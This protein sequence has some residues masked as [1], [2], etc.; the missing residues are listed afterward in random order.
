M[1]DHRRWL[2]CNESYPDRNALMAQLVPAG[3]TVLDVGAGQMTLRQ[4]LPPG[5]AYTPLDLYPRSPDTLVC[6]LNKREWPA[7]KWDV[8]VCSGV[9]EY[10]ADPEWL[11]D[12]LA[13]SAGLVI[14]SYHGAATSER[15]RGYGFLTEMSPGQLPE[16]A[17]R[18]G[19]EIV[20]VQPF[21]EQAIYAMVRKERHIKEAPP[22]DPA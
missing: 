7:G 10:V 12:R 14:A 20:E 21:G 3:R 13:E 18:S 17:R 22:Y 8:A 5:C 19:L 9:I 15:G 16:V 4:Y 6:D 1:T 11:F 2:G